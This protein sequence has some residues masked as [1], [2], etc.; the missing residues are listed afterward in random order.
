MFRLTLTR[1]MHDRKI[2]N[3]T[4]SRTIPP[5]LSSYDSP[6]KFDHHKA[7]KEEPRIWKRLWPKF[8]VHSQQ[9]RQY[10][11]M[12]IFY[13]SEDIKLGFHDM[14]SDFRAKR[15][16]VVTVPKRGYKATRGDGRP[17]DSWNRQPNMFDVEDK[18]WTSDPE[19][20][21][22]HEHAEAEEEAIW[23]EINHDYTDIDGVESELKGEALTSFKKLFKKK[24]T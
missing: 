12:P 21:K 16:I 1:A 7:N 10:G 17:I 22:P 19:R 23:G 14:G 3:I 13:T 2:P 24:T 4:R 6:K 9:Y 11:L 20:P 8:R 15:K 5:V 18:L